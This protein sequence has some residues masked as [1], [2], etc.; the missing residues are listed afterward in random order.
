MAGPYELCDADN[1][2]RGRARPAETLPDRR[3][4]NGLSCLQFV[5]ALK[6]LGRCLSRVDFTGTSRATGCHSASPTRDTVWSRNVYVEMKDDGVAPDSVAGDGWHTV[7]FASGGRLLH[8]GSSERPAARQTP[9]RPRSLT[10][11]LSQRL[12]RRQLLCALL[13]PGRSGAVGAILDQDLDREGAVVARTLLHRHA[14]SRLWPSVSLRVLQQE[15]LVVVVLLR[16]DVQVD[17][18]EHGPMNEAPRLVESG[19]Q[20]DRPDDCFECIRENGDTATSARLLH[21]LAHDDLRPEVDRPR[22]PRQCLSIDQLGAQFRQKALVTIGELVVQ[23]LGDDEAE[24]GIAQKFE[25]LVGNEVTLR[26]GSE[27]RT[28]REGALIKRHIADRDAGQFLDLLPRHAA[29]RDWERTNFRRFWWSR[30]TPEEGKAEESDPVAHARRESLV[31]PRLRAANTTANYTGGKRQNAHIMA[32]QSINPATEEVV[33]EYEQ[34]SP[35]EVDD[36]LNRS[37][38]AFER[39]RS[40]TFNDRAVRMRR[41]AELLE[42]RARQ[43]GEIMTV[44]MGKP[45]RQAEAEI[46]KCAWVC[47][48]YADEAERF[49]RPESVE[50]DAIRSYIAFQPLGAVLAV[51]PWNFPFWQVFR[52]A[53]PA[54]MAGNVGLLKHASNVT[55]CALAIE[56]SFR[57]G[58]FSGDEFQALIVGSDQVSSIIEDRRV[59][60]AT[61]TGSVGAGRSVA[62]ASG[63]QLKPSVLE[64]GGSDP[65]IVLNDSDLDE[66][67]DVGVRS[68]MQN[69]SQSCIAA[70]R[71]IVERDVADEFSRRFVHRIEQL[72]IGNPMNEDTEV[73][74]LARGDLR[75]EVHDQVQRALGEGARLLTGG[76]KLDGRGFFYAPTALGD[77]EPGMVPFV[78]EIFGPVASIS[79]AQDVDHAVHLAND[80]PFGLGGAVFTTDL[81]KGEEVALRLEVGCA[82]VNG[83][84]KSDPRIPFGGVKESGYGR[85]LSVYGIREFVNIK[86]VWIGG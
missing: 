30:P 86:S 69:N 33:A 23:L 22:T 24:N 3:R 51:M 60:A 4:G 81:K 42:S 66:A 63:K 85:E 70:K 29:P 49:L 27:D 48:Y 75:E 57:D 34:L 7:K 84:V 43:Y 65:F 47:R 31:R 18:L 2:R 74:P 37:V 16:E 72:R 61:V 79:V 56:E 59:A 77:V 45:I 20:I 82:F 10:F 64:L 39:H 62:E 28:M 9:D 83:M 8:F 1:I 25:A 26:V 40:T 52:F 32:V 19:V 71:F 54:L 6:G 50:T 36:C 53:A 38:R 67:V 76:E 13:A 14:I 73:G 35:D 80:S 15:T 41:V 5:A 58:G 21:V 55:G 78:E 12:V 44:E 11:E 46:R 68:R 17:V